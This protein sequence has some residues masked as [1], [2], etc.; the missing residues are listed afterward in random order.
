MI[1]D[2][3][4]YE[5]FRERLAEANP[6]EFYPLG[7]LDQQVLSGL[8]FPIIGDKSAMVVGLRLY[9]GGARVGHIKAAAGDM[10]ELI[11]ELGPRAS[12]WGR[13]HG[14]TVA[15]IEGRHGW[16]R[17]LRQHGWRHHSVTLLKDL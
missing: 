5:R 8:A 14:C 3:V 11:S 17:A 6:P 7:W 12:E 15:M 16:S 4:G 9:P 2:L 10:D 1:P 13:E